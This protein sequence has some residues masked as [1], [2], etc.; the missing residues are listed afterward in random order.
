MLQKATLIR[1]NFNTATLESAS[2]RE[3]NFEDP[4]EQPAYLESE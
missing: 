4:H 3:C 1:T 2:L